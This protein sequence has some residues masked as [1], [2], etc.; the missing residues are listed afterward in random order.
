MISYPVKV[1]QMHALDDRGVLACISLRLPT[2]MANRLDEEVERRRK[3]MP[4]A[5]VNRSDLL[6]EIVG[7]FLSRRAA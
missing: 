4:F 6:R 2:E 5:V 7:D 1:V 3:T